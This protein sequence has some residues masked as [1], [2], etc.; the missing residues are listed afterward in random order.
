MDNQQGQLHKEYDEEFGEQNVITVGNHA[1]LPKIVLRRGERFNICL[2][3]LTALHDEYFLAI[4]DTEEGTKGARPALKSKMDS[5]LELAYD[6]DIEKLRRK[7]YLDCVLE[8]SEQEALNRRLTPQTWRNWWWIFK[9]HK[10]QAQIL[11]DERIRRKALIKLKEQADALPMLPED[12]EGNEEELL[13]FEVIIDN[14]LCALPRMRKKRREWLKE[15]IEQ[16]YD[17]YAKKADE[18]KRL[19]DELE[20]ARRLKAE[21]EERAERAENMLD[22]FLKESTPAPEETANTEE[23]PAEEPK[24]PEEAEQTEAEPEEEDG[25]A[26]ET[27]QTTEEAESEPADEEEDDGLSYAGL[28]EE[29]E[30]E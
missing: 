11:Q 20:E 3:E 7:N 21:A 22:E 2:K 12:D 29:D 15:L 26:L 10:N 6:E 25:E 27:E 17:G 19:A 1:D 28:G 9:L 8:E 23:K 13:P 14:L 5:A 4:S 16:L 24:T 18:G 30:Q